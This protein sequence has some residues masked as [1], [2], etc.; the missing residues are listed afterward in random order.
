MHI[1]SIK[2]DNNY[3]LFYYLLQP[4]LLV[5][6][7]PEI[8]LLLDSTLWCLSIAKNLSTFGQRILLISYNKNKA[9]ISRLTL[10]FLL[11]ILP[12]YIKDITEQKFTKYELLQKTI[13]FCQHLYILLSIINFFRFLKTGKYPTLL[14]FILRW[15]LITHEPSKYRRV[16][17]DYMTR[18]LIW[19]GFMVR[20][21]KTRKYFYE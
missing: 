21:E 3:C 18:E 13:D 11:S 12:K 5:K 9:T 16:G 6:Y 2:H 14:D 10:H 17:Y 15:D 1:L 20:Q 4:S 7:Q 8:N 19:A